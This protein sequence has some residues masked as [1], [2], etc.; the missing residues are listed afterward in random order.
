MDSHNL[1]QYFP[2]SKNNTNP[3]QTMTSNIL[4]NNLDQS[5]FISHYD[6]KYLINSNRERETYSQRNTGIIPEDL[7]KTMQMMSSNLEKVLG[8]FEGFL[9][10]S[11][12]SN[13]IY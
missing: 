13:V 4:V 5:N 3:E 1:S 11:D 12:V 10:R 6:A 2:G 9:Q 7:T 8:Q